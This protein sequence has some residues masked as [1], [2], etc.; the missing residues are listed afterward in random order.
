MCRDR[1]KRLTYALLATFSLVAA[2][3]TITPPAQ[4]NYTNRL[5]KFTFGGGD[6]V[7][8]F[9]FDSTT[10]SSRNIDFP[11][12]ILYYG[13]ASVNYVKGELTTYQFVGTAMHYLMNDVGSG[14]TGL[15]W[16]S[17]D[18]VKTGVPLCFNSTRHTRIYAPATGAHPDQFYNPNYGYMAFAT[19]HYDHHELIG[20]CGPYYN[21]SEGTEKNI[22]NY[23]KTYD[24]KVS[25][26][27]DYG[28]CYN[29][30]G[31]LKE[32][33]HQYNQDGKCTYIHMP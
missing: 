25:V 26:F 17:D 30:M 7:Y 4:A 15:T 21:D 3:A 29:N 11:L 18:G 28:P 23:F 10:L 27:Y 2:V 33:N 5:T 24:P 20:H 16:D 8:N 12:T 19:T 1:I 9:D 31:G 32:G 22:A 13:N 6:Y 14:G